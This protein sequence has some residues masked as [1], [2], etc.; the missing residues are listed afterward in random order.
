MDVTVEVGAVSRIDARFEPDPNNSQLGTITIVAFDKNNNPT[1]TR[2]VKI[3]T[4]GGKAETA[5]GA[6]GA[7]GDFVTAV[8]WDSKA[9]ERNYK[10]TIEDIVSESKLGPADDY[11]VPVPNPRPGAVPAM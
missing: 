7:K 11:A 8:T 3:E 10:V 1:P 9:S 5:A 4:K 2:D 6:T